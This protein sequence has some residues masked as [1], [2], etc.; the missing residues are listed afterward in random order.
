VATKKEHTYEKNGK[1]KIAMRVVD[2][3]GN[4]ATAIIDIKL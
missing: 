2:I 3:F 4:D 1:H